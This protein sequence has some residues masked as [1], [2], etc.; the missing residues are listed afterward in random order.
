MSASVMAAWHVQ[1][2]A[3]FAR[4]VSSPLRLRCYW[5]NRA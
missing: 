4:L 2:A 1:G 3:A 5:Q